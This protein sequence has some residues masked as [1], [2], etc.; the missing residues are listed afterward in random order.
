MLYFIWNEMMYIF[1]DINKEGNYRKIRQ[2]QLMT[3]RKLVLELEKT[4]LDYR[5][6]LERY[7]DYLKRFTD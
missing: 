7:A 1:Q 6:R 3:I 4:R 5:K 2:V